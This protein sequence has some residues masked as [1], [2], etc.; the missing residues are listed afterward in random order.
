MRYL[1]ITLLLL[2]CSTIAFS[3]T[4][5]RLKGIDK[6]LE[7]LLETWN[8]AGFAVAIVEKNNVIYSKGFGYA[9]YEN[10]TPADASTLFAI[11]SCTKAFTTSLLGML[12]DDGQLSF[13]DNP[14]KYVPELTFYDPSISQS[15][16][17]RDLIAHRTGVPRHDFSWYLFPTDSKDS[18]IS[19]IQYH[20]PFASFRER[21]YY[22]N[23]MYLTQGVITERVTGKSWEE[24]IKERIFNP[25]GMDRS[26]TS[27]YEAEEVQ[28]TA[29][30]Y[31]VKDDQIKF[32]DYYRISGMAP[33]G[34]IYSSADDMAKWLKVWIN[35]GKFEDQELLKPGYVTEAISSQMV[36]SPSLP[37]ADRAGLHFSNYGFAWGLSSY[38]GHYRV[39]HG[40][41]IDG[42]SASTSFFPS[43]SI[44]IVVLCNQDGSS[45][46]AMAR[47]MIADRM[48]NLDKYDWSGTAKKQLE[49]ARAA[50]SSKEDANRKM[51]TTPSHIAE[52]F[53]GK[54]T[55]PG[56]GSFTITTSNDSLFA[57]FKRMKMY[58][59]HYHYNVFT[60]LE[61]TNDGIDT[62]DTGGLKF[63]F[64]V[65]DNGDI[66]AV[67]MKI[68]P[69]I[70]DPIRFTRTPLKVDVSLEQMKAYEGTY[71]LG[72]METKIHLEEDV[73]FFFVPGQKD[74]ELIPIGEHLFGVKSLQGFKVEFIQDEGGK[75]DTLK[76]IQPNGTFEAKRK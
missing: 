37:R 14:R 31:N 25:L 39:E 52:S 13:E 66:D 67:A 38:K 10:K 27:S 1:I 42:F 4:D 51:G 32:M 41:N 50:S 40:G 63:N 29:K 22:N 33:A 5:K 53:A 65:G 56:Y 62:V 72:G 3:Q 7:Q 73:L 23:F 48:L 47:N 46:P 15:V 69:A 61:V 26:R 30:G 76:A 58:L 18:L 71:Q 21:W 64:S 12:Q 59:N 9:D 44:G 20:Q 45:V 35:G 19:R 17:I 2:S 6:E 60:P 36:A 8:A 54:Y 55:H 57:N 24:N 43:D 49:E 70:E 34:S 16:T 74:Y 11:G 28:N 75:F 68:E